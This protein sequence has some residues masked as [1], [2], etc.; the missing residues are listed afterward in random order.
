MEA[1]QP[2]PHWPLLP[3]QVATEPLEQAARDIL[4]TAK[5]TQ[6]LYDLCSAEQAAEANWIG[7]P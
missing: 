5:E 7:K 1:M 3:E 2:C 6:K 4:A